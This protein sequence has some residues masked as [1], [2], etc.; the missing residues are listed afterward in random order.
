VQES[1]HPDGGGIADQQGG[2]Q[3]T[4][5]QQATQQRDQGRVERGEGRR[6]VARPSIA[7]T[8][9]LGVPQ[10]IPA[11]PGFEQIVGEEGVVRGGFCIAPGQGRI[12]FYREGEY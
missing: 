11:Q 7:V 9:D 5:G 1:E 2:Q 12:G 4:A 8:G 3:V 10:P 6:A